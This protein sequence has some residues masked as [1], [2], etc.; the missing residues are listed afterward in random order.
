MSNKSRWLVFV[1]NEPF[2]NWE[3]RKNIGLLGRI[4]KKHSNCAKHKRL[5]SFFFVGAHNCIDKVSNVIFKS[6]KEQ[7]VAQCGDLAGKRC[8]LEKIRKGEKGL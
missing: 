8:K 1:K 4:N 6:G 7:P 5:R 3:T 2:D